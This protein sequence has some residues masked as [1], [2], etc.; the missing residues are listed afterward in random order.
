MMSDPQALHFAT[1]VA[2]DHVVCI[3][4][5]KCEHS[6]MCKSCFRVAPRQKPPCTPSS[7]YS[8]DVSCTMWH[9]YLEHIVPDNN[10]G[11]TETLTPQRG[12][13]TQYF[14]DLLGSA[15]SLCGPSPAHHKHSSD[16]APPQRLKRMSGN[17]RFCQLVR[18]AEQD[19]GTVQSN[20][21]LYEKI[22]DVKNGQPEF[23]GIDEVLKDGGTL[24][25][26]ARSKSILK[27]RSYNGGLN[28]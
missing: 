27:L 17:V 18:A 25:L 21:P 12:F 6:P 15:R 23:G 22:C 8:L 19:A 20:V 28:L 4:V 16:L 11:L 2:L 26:L 13:L 10:H 14:S 24:R 1:G 3:H 9:T 7:R 5:H